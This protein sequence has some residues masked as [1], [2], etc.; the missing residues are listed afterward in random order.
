MAVKDSTSEDVHSLN[1]RAKRLCENVWQHP[2]TWGQDHAEA[3]AILK[4]ALKLDK[5]NTTTLTN[6]GAVL[7]NMGKHKEALKILRKAELIGTS[8]RNLFF[9]IGVVLMDLSDTTRLN[10]RD[11]FELASTMEPSIDTFEAYFDPQGH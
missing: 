2:E 6:I 9:N 1:T 11:Y 10:A 7:S 5:M 3:H 8:D 4:R